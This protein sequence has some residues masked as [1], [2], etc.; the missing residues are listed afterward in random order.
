MQAI[1][2]GALKF[3]FSNATVHVKLI[4]DFLA[5]MSNKLEELLEHYRVM[6]YWYVYHL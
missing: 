1:H 4:P 3:T 6:I 5:P 2:V